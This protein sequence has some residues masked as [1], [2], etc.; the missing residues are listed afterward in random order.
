MTKQ[1][2]TKTKT[3]KNNKKDSLENATDN[4]MSTMFDM[5]DMLSNMNALLNKKEEKKEETTKAVET[6]NKVKFDMFDAKVTKD[7]QKSALMKSD[8]KNKAK[9]KNQTEN[10]RLT[11]FKLKNN[12]I[13]RTFVVETALNVA[14]RSLDKVTCQ[15]IVLFI[16]QVLTLTSFKYKRETSNIQRVR[17]HVK[18]TIRLESASD[19]YSFDEASQTIVFSKE[20]IAENRKN[21]VHMNTVDNDMNEIIAYAKSVNHVIS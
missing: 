10:V 2:V 19:C 3:R 21:S 1:Q 18:D 5:N 11:S 7:Y 12:V 16:E 4:V 14:S 9:E 17:N 13:N 8:T 6:T 20:F 15:Q